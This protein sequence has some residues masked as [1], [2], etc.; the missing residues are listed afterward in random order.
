[1][2]LLYTYIFYF[3]IPLI[4][5]RLLWR[6]IKAPQYRQRWPERF[7]FFP[8]SAKLIQPTL[9]LH[10]VSVGETIAVKPLV[11]SLLQRYPN[12]QVV[13]TTM[14]PTGSAQ[15]LSL[16]AD[17]IEGQRV[18]HSYIPYDLPDCLERFLFRTNPQLAIFMETEV[19]PNTLRACQK[20]NIPSVLINARLSKKSF[21]SYQNFSC[22]SRQTF[23][24][25]TQ[26][27]AQTQAEAERIK[28]LGAPSIV[29]AGS[30]KAEVLLTDE[31]KSQARKLKKNWSCNGDKK[32]I[33]A[34]S[35]HHGEDE[36]ILAA[37]Q[38]LVNQ[39]PQ[40]MLVIVPRHPE[41]FA[42]VAQLCVDEGLVTVRR[43]EKSAITGDTQVIV[44][45]TMGELLLMLGATDIVIMCGSFIKHGGHNML[46]PAAWGLP[47]LS[48]SSVY[49]FSKIV[50]DMLSL[51]ALVLVKDQH[52]LAEKLGG[53][54]GGPSTAALMGEQAKA[55]VEKSRGALDKTC[56]ELSKYIIH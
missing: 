30:L 45:D 4:L 17:M 14:T 42:S 32:I 1:M 55:Y 20:K 53:L 21:K 50:E 22:L 47:I 48:G 10:S 51:N 24:R 19:W 44:G 40:L 18:A 27:I 9:W 52:Q 13:I 33:I 31:L 25:I 36:I 41:R 37:Y 5:L 39:Y 35:S 16:F 34:A 56:A 46:E 3:A 6:S 12:H 26:V 15:V 2:R 23:A 49:N 54:L 7:G 29:V 8:A 28:L 11:D 43:S 38:K